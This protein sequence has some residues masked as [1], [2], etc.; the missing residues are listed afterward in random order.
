MLDS[1]IPLCKKLS[2][3]RCLLMAQGINGVCSG[4]PGDWIDPKKDADFSEV[5]YE[6]LDIM[7]ME[8][9]PG[10]RGYGVDNTVHHP[11]SDPW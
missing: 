5:F 8:M 1:E 3:K 9:P 2:K 4:C 10:S 11:D 6:D 7:K